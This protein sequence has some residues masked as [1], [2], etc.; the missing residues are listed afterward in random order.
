[1]VV[2]VEAAGG[3][4]GEVDAMFGGLAGGGQ[5]HLGGIACGGHDDGVVCLGLVA[6]SRSAG[7]WA[8]SHDGPYHGVDESVAGDFGEV[9]MVPDGVGV[10][11]GQGVE[12]VAGM[13]MTGVFGWVL[14]WPGRDLVDGLRWGA[15]AGTGDGVELVEEPPSVV[16]WGVGRGVYRDSAGGGEGYRRVEGRSGRSATWASGPRSRRSRR[17]GAGGSPDGRRRLS[18]RCF[19]VLRGLPVGGV[20]VE[21]LGELFL[22][23]LVLEGDGATGFDLSAHGASQFVDAVLMGLGLGRVLGLG[24]LSEGAQF[25]GGVGR[26]GVG[27]VVHVHEVAHDLVDGT[28]GDVLVVGGND[29]IAGSVLVLVDAV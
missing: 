27:G 9:E 26:V 13:A 28:A 16:V 12:P 7:R 22:E 4:W 17:W 8:M 19:G 18:S 1:M 23:N 10:A 14:A 6:S 25:S 15:Q 21:G 20:F 3:G 29:G 2:E 24:E 11:V 5:G